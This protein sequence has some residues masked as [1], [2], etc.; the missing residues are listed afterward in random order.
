MSRL[1]RSLS[2]AALAATCIAALA[3]ALSAQDTHSGPRVRKV[4]SIGHHPR[5]DG[6]RINYR[7]RDVDLVR[8]AN[9]TIWSPYEDFSGGQVIGAAIGLPLTVAGDI[10]GVGLGLAGVGAQENMHGIMLG[11]LGVGAGGDVRGLALGG[12]GLGAGGDLRG[13]AVGG[14]GAGVGGSVRGAAAG[15]VGVGAGGNVRGI[16]VGGIGAGIGGDLRGLAVGGIGA[17]VGGS[18]RGIAVGGL[19]VGAGGNVRGITVGGIGVGAGGSIRGISIGGFG[20]G[21]GNGIHG[22]TVG[23]IGVGTGGTA[24]GIAVAG[25]GVGAPR[26]RGG[27]AA[28]IVGTE[29]ARGVV[30]APALFRTERGGRLTGASLSSVNAIR[31]TQHGLT[32][33]LVN[34]AERLQGVQIGAIN[35]NKGAS[36]PFKVL[37]II[38]VGR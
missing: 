27:A 32:I 5:V 25:L 30:I 7:D 28:M 12:V 26:I 8:G 10:R 13:I 31:G 22:I 3:T 15:L 35:I 24:S 33:G 2:T 11:G 6:I 23:G 21:A 38:N 17:G 19:G 9:I 1:L 34:Y 14:I 29:N 16:A 20:V 37:P 4:L 36:G 18:V